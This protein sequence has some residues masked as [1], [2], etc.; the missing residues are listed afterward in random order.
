M[1]NSSLPL[2]LYGAGQ[3][4]IKEL[5]LIRSNGMSPLCFCDS[6]AKKQGTIY[7]GL[8]VISLEQTIKKYKDFEV[9]LTPSLTIIKREI[10][11]NLTKHGIKIERIINCEEEHYKG[12]RFLESHMEAYTSKI[13]ICGVANNEMNESPFVTFQENTHCA[14]IGAAISQWVSLRDRL[15][16]SIR[17]GIPTKCDGCCCIEDGWW[18]TDKKI[19]TLTLIANFQCQLSCYY[20]GLGNGT[21]SVEKESDIFDWK[22]FVESLEKQNLLS[23]ETVFGL[24][25]GELTIDPRKDE[26]LDILQK[27]KLAVFTNA[28]VFDER[29]AEMTAR[30]GNWL[31]ISVDAGTAETYKQ[32]KGLDVFAEVWGNIKKYAERGVTINVKY[33]FLPENST[34]A[35]VDGF[36]K[37]VSKIVS[38]DIRIVISSNF[39]RQSPHTKEQIRL[40]ARMYSFSNKKGI[41]VTIDSTYKADEIEMI[42]KIAQAVS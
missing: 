42:Y 4:A 29:T 6:D 5:E 25:G 18:A 32:L 34:E 27:Y 19:K 11:D 28:V 26:L 3:N 40:I 38:N 13:A 33:I 36:I 16:Y 39:F 15:I 24:A 22:C 17:N 2:I 9:Y 14:E 30:L 8:P 31:I 37:E 1:K 21:L 7:L 23:D 12:C 10:I 41:P 35:D 20:C